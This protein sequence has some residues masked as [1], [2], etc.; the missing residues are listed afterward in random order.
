MQANLKKARAFL[1]AK[2]PVHVIVD[3]KR[4]RRKQRRGLLG[5]K[6][7]TKMRYWSFA[8]FVQSAGVAVVQLVRANGCHDPDA[9]GVGHQ[10]RM[11]DQITP[12]Y[13]HYYVTSSVIRVKFQVPT[14]SSPVIC[15]LGLKDS[16]TTSASG[17]EYGELRNVVI[18][19][20]TSEKP[21]SL[22]LRY[23]TKQFLGIDPDNDKN[24]GNARGG[25]SSTDPVD[26]AYFHIVMADLAGNTVTTQASYTIDYNV[27]FIEPRQP[28]QS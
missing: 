23:N 5:N 17:T 20:C 9:S 19:T 22:S 12:L 8:S 11:W 25:A 26:Q 16:N 18:G 13:D 3:K 7:S 6:F 1:D 4:R 28:S 10:P 14:A 24:I 27:A 2:A 21:L 15:Y